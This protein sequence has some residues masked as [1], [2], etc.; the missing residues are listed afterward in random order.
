MQPKI[1]C[2]IGLGYIGLPTAALLAG[3]GYQVIGVDVNP[4]TVE[5]INQGQIHIVEPDLD[6]FVRSAVSS[7]KLKAQTEP[8]QAD[9]F[10]V[11]VPTPLS[12]RRDGIPQPD[13]SYVESAVRS[14]APCLKS[15]NS[16]ILESTSPVGTTAA[17]AHVLSGLGVDVSKLHIAY[18]PERVLP[19]KIMTELVENDRV[20][21]G[22]LPSASEV[23]AEFYKTFVR[24]AVIQTDAPTAEMCKLAEN[25][26]RDVNIAYAN[27]LSLICANAGINVSKLIELANRH[28]R[29]NI[30][31]P[32]VGVGGHCIAVDPWFVVAKDPENARL[33][34]AARNVNDY[35]TEWVVTQISQELSRLQAT[36]KRKP[37]VACFGL[38]FKPDIDDLRES[39]ALMVA[40]KVAKLDCDLLVVEPNIEHYD[41]FTLCTLMDAYDSADLLIFLVKHRQFIDLVRRTSLSGKATLDYCGIL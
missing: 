19:G 15:G 5:T 41:A 16:V 8:T 4:K 10:I 20:V 33:I 24:G 2:V 40:E 35:K 29:V 37:K 38:A 25:S 7:G 31:T 34:H 11:C 1:V 27:E 39:P 9:I 6:A 32:G 36:L 23:V 12:E 13:I 22:L 21:G 17:M 3:K 26:Y 18:C 28:P 30:L 14:L